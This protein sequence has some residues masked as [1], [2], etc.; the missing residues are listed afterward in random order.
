MKLGALFW[1]ENPEDVVEKGQE[2]V[3]FEDG[4]EE[5]KL[6]ENAKEDDPDA[7][8]AVTVEAGDESMLL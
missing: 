8:E 3:E 4:V 5:N 6:E 7:E 1:K 2:Q